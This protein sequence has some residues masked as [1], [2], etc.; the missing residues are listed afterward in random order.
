MRFQNNN[1]NSFI[2]F[3]D[4]FPKIQNKTQM[5]KMKIKSKCFRHAN[6]PRC[7]IIIEC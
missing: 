3:F 2:I 7:H 5:L 6:R 1:E 4:C